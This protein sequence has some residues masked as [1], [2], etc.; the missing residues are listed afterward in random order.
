M[1]IRIADSID[2]RRIVEC[3]ENSYSKYVE[4]IGKK[5][6]PML[7]DYK[8]KIENKYIHVIDQGGR[9]LWIIVLI[10]MDDHLYLGNLAV[11]PSDQGKGLGRM[12]MNYAEKQA[13]SSG[14]TEIRL[15]TNELMH[16]NIII[17]K[18]YGYLEIERKTENG[19]NRVFFVKK[20]EVEQIH[21]PAR[22]SPPVN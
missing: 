1:L 21:S 6:A 13:V 20:L 2:E 10:P 3:I 12:L 9:I 22:K 7:D 4:R 15:Y 14:F 18:K 5:P 8:S 17:Y 11:Q 16:E 19:Y